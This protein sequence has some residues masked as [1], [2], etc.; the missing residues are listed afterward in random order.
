V[1]AR[2]GLR[3]AGGRGKGASDGGRGGCLRQ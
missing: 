2:K 1:H 3:D